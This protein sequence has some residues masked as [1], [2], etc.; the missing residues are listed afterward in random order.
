ME[1]VTAHV[2]ILVVDDEP[3]FRALLEW[4]LATS[5]WRVTVVSNGQEAISFLDQHPDFDLVITDLTMPHVGGLA[6]LENIQARSPKPAVIVI[7]GFST[8]ETAVHAMQL[9]AHD[10]LLKPFK[11][12]DLFESVH[13]AL[14]KKWFRTA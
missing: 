6:L 1:D 3:G 10:V 14:A 9:G 11:L 7:T 12:T 13:R 4:R 5:Q 8:I 2:K